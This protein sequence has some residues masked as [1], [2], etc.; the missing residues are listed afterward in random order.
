MIRRYG[1]R[2]TRA[3]IVVQTGFTESE[4]TN[5]LNQLAL[6]TASRLEVK[7]T[8]DILYCFP[9]V[10]WYE[11]NVLRKAL[12][13]NLWLLSLLAYYITVSVFRFFLLW[14]LFIVVPAAL[15]VSFAALVVLILRTF[16]LGGASSSVL[17][18]LTMAVLGLG[19]YFMHK[20]GPLFLQTAILAI[21]EFFSDCQSFVVG[22]PRTDRIF[23]LEMWHKMG[24]FIRQHGGVA[25]TE[26]LSQ[27]TGTDV[28][29]DGRI[30]PILVRLEGDPE[31]T[32]SGNIVYTFPSLM[33]SA[34]VTVGSDVSNRSEEPLWQLTNIS[35]NKKLLVFIYATINF[36][37]YMALLKILNPTPHLHW[38]TMVLY[39]SLGF[40]IFFFIYP[41]FRALILMLLNRPI[42]RRNAYRRY[43]TMLLASPSTELRQKLQESREHKKQFTE[44][45][46]E[47]TVYR[48][49]K[50]VLE[51]QF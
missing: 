11:A 50:D 1:G 6:D 18:F 20:S 7:A 19:V 33:I 24:N 21:K 49:D 26:E 8:G 29:K 42:V 34:D 16:A 39:L 13:R 48:T 3:D 25:T 51:Q 32:A 22:V 5:Q 37:G 30:F 43:V 10:A 41:L 46:R 47:K 2:V 36:M 40:S 38:L 4:V 17:M 35:N 9:N 31:V 28:Q 44:V 27:F 23:E 15:T 14:S 45:E 12:S